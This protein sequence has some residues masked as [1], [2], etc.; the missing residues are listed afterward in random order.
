M[1]R[2]KNKTVYPLAVFLVLV[3]FVELGRAEVITNNFTGTITSVSGTPFGLSPSIGQQI[4]GSFTYD[5]SQPPAFDTGTVAGYIQSPPSGMSLVI[6]GLTIQSENHNSFQVINDDPSPLDN[7]NGFFTPIFAGGVLQPGFSSMSFSLSD[8]TLTALS[9]TALPLSLDLAS[10]SQRGGS[11]FDEGSGGSL[12]FSIDSPAG[13]AD[14]DGVLDDE[15]GCPDSNLSVTVIIDGCNS[16][17]S[18]TLFPSGCTIS[19][20]ISGCAEGARNHGQFVSCV[21]HLTKG[22]KRAGA[23]SGRQKGAIQRCATQADIP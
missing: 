16:G 9:S 13:D 17:V 5:T 3:S 14:G 20:G 7:I 23:I 22:L 6:S 11:I 8:F 18:N 21:P 10:F 19:D 12:S 2:L 4:Q 1:K 15:D